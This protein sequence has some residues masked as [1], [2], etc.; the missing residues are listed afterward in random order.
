MQQEVTLNKGKHLLVLSASHR[1][2]SNSDILCDQFIKG[3]EASGHRAEKILLKDRKIN[4]CA[5]CGVCKKNGGQCVHKDDMPEILEKMTAACG[6]VLATPVYFYTMSAQMKALIDRTYSRYSQMHNKMVYLIVTGAANEKPYMETAFAG[7]RGFLK[8][9]PN[10]VEK[11]V[12]YGIDA[13]QPGDV[14]NSPAMR[15]AYEMGQSV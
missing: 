13:P 7:L 10:A 5:G 15:E 9:M 2:G 6:I 12:I 1:I 14:K 8:C 11:G 4:Y 3:A